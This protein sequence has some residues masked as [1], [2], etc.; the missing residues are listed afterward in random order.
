MSITSI[1]KENF[2]KS[3]KLLVNEFHAHDIDHSE[4]GRMGFWVPNL[5]GKDIY[6]EISRDSDVC[7]FDNDVMENLINSTIYEKIIS[8]N[9]VPQTPHRT[10]TK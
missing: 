4:G 9:L 1:K 8:L 3:L 5:D 10:F 2:Q 7:F 6:G